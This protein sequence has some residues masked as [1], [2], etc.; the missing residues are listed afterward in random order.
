M[1]LLPVAAMPAIC[2]VS[3][4]RASPA[5]RMNMRTSGGDPSGTGTIAFSITQSACITPDPQ[6]H[7]PVSLTPPSTGSARPGGDA[8]LGAMT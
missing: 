2:Q 6:F 7:R 4:T 3:M 5:G 1:S 8:Q